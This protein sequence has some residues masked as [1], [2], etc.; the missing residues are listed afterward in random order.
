[1]SKSGARQ[2]ILDTAAR[3]FARDG[4]ESVSLRTINTE[5]GYSVAALHYHFRTREALIEALFEQRRRDVLERR[6]ALLSAMEL[7]ESIDLI[8][9]TEALVLPFAEL[10]FDNPERG[11]TTIKLFFRLYVER[12]DD[13]R[14]KQETEAS[15]RIFGQLLGEV[16]PQ[17]EQNTMR[18]RWTLATEL[19]FQG[20][21]NVESILGSKGR[22]LQRADYE[23]YTVQLID[24]IAGGLAAPERSVYAPKRRASA[25][26][27]RRS[28]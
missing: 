14:V 27:L 19:T 22:K 3:L 12:R 6:K 13:Q 21:A 2:A 1:M 28:R 20:L 10:L 4:F 15:F 8:R 23:D 11:L 24:F 18:K 5:A 26:R 9:I 25:A 16:L 17:V 7:D